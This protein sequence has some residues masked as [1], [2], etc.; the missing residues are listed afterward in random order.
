MEPARWICSRSQ[1]RRSASPTAGV[2]AARE[3]LADARYSS[4][5]GSAI[6]LG[7]AQVALATAGAQVVQA[8]FNLSL[9][10]ADLLNALGQR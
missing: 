9:A 5:V 4:G 7:D 3:R 1:F 10:R 8:Q 2:E 6:E